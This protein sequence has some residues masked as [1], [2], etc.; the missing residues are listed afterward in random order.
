MFRFAELMR[1]SGVVKE[2]TLKGELCKNNKWEIS[3]VIR[4]IS[5]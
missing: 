4:Y 5:A 2:S 1:T 3:P